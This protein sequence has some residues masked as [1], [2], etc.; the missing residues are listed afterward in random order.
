MVVGLAL[1]DHGR[2]PTLKGLAGRDDRCRRAA[3]L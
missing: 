1:K 3:P 2:Q